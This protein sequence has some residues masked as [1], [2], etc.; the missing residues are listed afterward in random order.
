MRGISDPAGPD[1]PLTSHGPVVRDLYATI[2]RLRRVVLACL[3]ALALGTGLM[4]AAFQR[5]QHRIERL[6]RD[7]ARVVYE[8]CVDRNARAAA[9]GAALAKLVEASRADGDAHA[10]RVWREFVAASARTP[11]PECV[12]PQ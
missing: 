11:L 12:K 10:E 6:E 4:L 5:D 7:N 8:G 2:R 1:R 3:A 9:S